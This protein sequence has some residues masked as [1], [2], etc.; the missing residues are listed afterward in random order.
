MAVPENSP[1]L[2][3]AIATRIATAPQQRI[4]FAEY[5][6]WV[7][8]HPQHGYYGGGNAAIGAEG[9]FFT[10]ASLGSDWGEL[11]AEQFAEMWAVLGCPQPFSLVEVGAGQGQLAADILHHLQ[12]HQPQLLA[13]L[14]YTIV[15]QA[16]AL[17]ARQQERL[18]P[19][20]DRGVAIQW[21]SLEAIPPDSLTG[22]VFANEV[23]DAM[24]VHRVTLEGGRLREIYVTTASGQNGPF[25]ETSGELS[26]PRLAQYLRWVGIELPSPAYPDGYRTEVNLAALDWLQAIAERLHRGYV[27]IVDYGYSAQRYYSPQRHQGTLQCYTQHQR[28]AH[29]YAGI[30]RQDM[31][32]H[33]DWTALQ[34]QGEACRLAT[35]GLTQQGPFLMALGLGDRLAALSDGNWDVSTALRRRD[36]LH[37]LIDPAGLGNFGVLI[38]TKGLSEAERHRSL[39]GL[40]T[41]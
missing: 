3:D 12:Q 20:R 10:A 31:T 40:Q 33:V 5:M 14:D 27:L 38:Q 22:C 6:D 30:G 8:Y 37:Q 26:T 4:S 15:E 13:A 34:Q 7:L 24:P 23:A 29:P 35:L 25:A 28:N 39:K 21:R 1:A 17:A 36:A 32:A 41:P 11:L 16:P 9:D 19:W 18:Q 2:V